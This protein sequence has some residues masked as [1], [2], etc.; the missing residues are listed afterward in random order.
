MNEI[1]IRRPL[2]PTK[3]HFRHNLN[4]GLH[5][6]ATSRGSPEIGICLSP[7]TNNVNKDI[8]T[9]STKSLINI[10]CSD[11]ENASTRSDL[12]TQRALVDHIRD[13][14]INVGFFYGMYISTFE[15]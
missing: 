4:C 5:Q 2:S 6:H 8:T 1:G 11:L 7:Y 9:R 13:A 12:V 3:F 14:C 10:I 15:M